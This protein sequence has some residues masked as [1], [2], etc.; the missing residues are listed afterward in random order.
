MKQ[1]YPFYNPIRLSIVLLL[2]AFAPTIAFSQATY[3]PYSYHFYQKLNK[4]QYSP[5]TK[6]HTSIKPYIIDSIM[7]SAYDSLMNLGVKEQ[8]TWVGRKLF[9]EHLIDVQKE[10]YTFYAD[11]IPDFQIGRDF[12]SEGTTTWLNTRGYQVGGTIQDKFF[13]Y[14]SGYE[15]QGVFP[16]YVNDFINENRVVPGQMYGKLGKKT[17]DWTYVT[18]I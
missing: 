5:Q 9:N 11:F 6:Q 3:Q 7:V 13:F 8:N 12:T 17:Q 15:N 14:S 10:D 4:I 16:N 1:S 18:A 2:L